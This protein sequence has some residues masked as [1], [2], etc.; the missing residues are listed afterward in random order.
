M[1]DRVCFNPQISGRRQPPFDHDLCKVDVFS[2]HIL[3]HPEE[4]RI[5]YLQIPTTQVLTTDVFVDVDNLP[6]SP[7]QYNVVSNERKG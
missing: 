4:S 3:V 7:K 6:L 2:G 1:G 5:L